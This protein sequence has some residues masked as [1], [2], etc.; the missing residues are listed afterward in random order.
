MGKDQ[1]TGWMILLGSI[2][3]IIVYFY[4]VLLSP[5]TML[6]IQISAFIAVA[7]LLSIMAWIGYTLATTPPPTPIEDLDIEGIPTS[8]PETETQNK[9]QE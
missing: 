4:L 2:L 3:G 6:T 5:W 9:E 1:I 7:A 8:E